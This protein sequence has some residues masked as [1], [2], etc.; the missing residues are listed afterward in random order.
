MDGLAEMQSAGILEALVRV[1]GQ[2]VDVYTGGYVVEQV[3]EDLKVLAAQTALSRMNSAGEIDSATLT[4]YAEQVQAIQPVSLMGL[5]LLSDVDRWIQPPRI[6]DLR[7]TGIPLVDQWMGG[8]IGRELTLVMAD[9]GIGKTTMLC[10]LGNHSALLGGNVLHISME[11]STH[12]TLQRYYR[13]IAEASKGEMRSGS[14]ETARKVKHWLRYAKG[15]VAVLFE[16]AYT[17]TPQALRILCHRYVDKYGELDT[18]ILDYLDLMKPPAGTERLSE[19]QQLG[20]VTHLIRNMTEEFGCSIISATQS[21]R[22][23]SKNVPR[24]SEM[25]D[26]YGKVRAADNIFAIV[27]TDEEAEIYQGRLYCLKIRE[28]VGRGRA[29][30]LYMNMDL[31]IIAQLDHPNTERI[32]RELGHMPESPESDG[33]DSE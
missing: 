26:S 4:D 30:P 2:N 17:L 15:Q 21:V 14:E 3:V 10:N 22:G 19:Y 7:A 6:E 24:L 5:G 25:G 32:M 13:R 12:N 33:D 28:S 23:A 20:R 27:Q 8:G 16:E 18:L 1:Q 29:I 11:L 9:S 31:M